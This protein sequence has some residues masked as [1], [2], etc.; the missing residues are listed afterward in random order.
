MRLCRECF[1][2][3]GEGE[4]SGECEACCNAF[5]RLGEFA[6]RIAE[7]L[8]RYDFKTFNVGS[9][10]WGSIRALQE[11]L[12]LKGKD[13]DIKARFNTMLA[14]EIAK[15][16]GKQSQRSFDPEI[17]IL[18]DLETFSCEIHIKPVFI[19]GRYIKRVRDISQ[20]RWICGYCGGIGC[21]RCEFTGKKYL[22][23]EE[24][25]AIPA[26]KLF[27]ARDAKLHGAGRE[28]VDARMLGNG[29]PFVLEI[30]EPERRE[31][32][33]ERVERE[34]NDYCRGKVVVKD[35]EY[36][37]A[38]RVREVK[39]ARHRKVYRAKVV[40]DDV[41]DREK[42]LEALES[43]KGD[44]RQRTPQ[45]V[46]HRRA[47]RLRIRKLFDARLLHHSGRVAVIEFLADAGL[48]IKELVS[49][50]NGRTKPSLAEK[51]GVECRVEKLDVTGV[52][53]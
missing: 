17:L 6:E 34:I 35:M 21:E 26:I 20:T 29:R 49:G 40:F 33:L 8:S 13:Y 38:K 30:I 23:V 9:R 42:L 37:D 41:V 36:T 5:D 25:I 31:I 45:R 43:L 18:F 16:I 51:V 47:D 14:A 7:E 53:T 2:I 1:S 3:I 24:L 11:H 39:Q 28:D 22:S 46:S 32:D 4:I 44:I 10:V 27:K 15:R 12:S 48:Y 52:L 50:D 19:Y